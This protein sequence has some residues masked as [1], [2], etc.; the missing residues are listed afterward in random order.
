MLLAKT[1]SFYSLRAGDWAL[2]MTDPNNVPAVARAVEVVDQEAEEAITQ[3]NAVLA[4][5]L[6]ATSARLREIW[7]SLEGMRASTG[8]ARTAGSSPDYTQTRRD[9]AVSTV[10]SAISRAGD[11]IGDPEIVRN[12]SRGEHRDMWDLVVC[13]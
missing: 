13:R 1:G 12:Q 9:V 11:R 6:E 4:K 2:Q 3:G 7:K 8:S 5:D 10:T